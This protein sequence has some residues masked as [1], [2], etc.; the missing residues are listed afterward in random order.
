MTTKSIKT[1]LGRLG[2]N[3]FTCLSALSLLNLSPFTP[4]TLLSLLYLSFLSLLSLIIIL[5]SFSTFA[6]SKQVIQWAAASSS[7]APT[8]QATETPCCGRLRLWIW[9]IGDSFHS[10]STVSAEG[11]W[12]LTKA[13]GSSPWR[14]QGCVEKMLNQPVFQPTDMP[15]YNAWSCCFDARWWR[16]R[17]K[18][19]HQPRKEHLSG[20]IQWTPHIETLERV[21]FGMLVKHGP[22]S[23]RVQY[24]PLL[25]YLPATAT[26][27]TVQGLPS[28][29]EWPGRDRGGR[30]RM[31]QE[32]NRKQV[33]C[34]L[35]PKLAAG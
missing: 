15:W 11:G 13:S 9:L 10:H 3:S 29:I 12:L 18:D 6:F 27:D 25:L 8:R 28:L 16:D 4:L 32:V 30:N 5:V 7:E 21:L 31:S 24:V 20:R 34:N 26:N 22:C 1:K 17:Y 35:I 19:T 23:L 14:R 33:G 2:T